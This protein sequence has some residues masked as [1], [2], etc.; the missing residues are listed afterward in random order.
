MR[1]T[2]RAD[3]IW[4]AQLHHH[5]RGRARRAGEI[6]SVG[7]AALRRSPFR[8]GE[9]I[10]QIA[11][12]EIRKLAWLSFRPKESQ[13]D[14]SF[15]FESDRDK[16]EVHAGGD[17]TY[18]LAFYENVQTEMAAR[19]IEMRV[20]VNHGLV[21]L[22]FAEA[23]YSRAATN[24]GGPDLCTVTRSFAGRC[25]VD[26]RSLEDLRMEVVRGAEA[27]VAAGVLSGTQHGNWSVR[28]PGTDRI[29]LTGSSLGGLKP[30]DL[31]VLNLDG[32]VIEGGLSASSAE[33]IRMHTAVY[34]ERPEVGSV[35]HTHSPYATAFAVANRPL[36]CF[37]E[38][39]AR[40]GCSDPV[41]VAAYGPRGSEQAVANILEA[42]RQAPSQSAVLLGNHGILAF[43]ANVGA[44]RQ[45]VFALEETAQLGVLAA[46][47]GTPQAIPTHMVVA[48][49]AR[50]VTSATA[51]ASE[52]SSRQ[53]I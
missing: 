32:E 12:E 33:I 4:E 24:P 29:L 49:Q 34:L 46:A 21:F 17:I 26:E 28:I 43:G 30:T 13:S 18:Q 39:L 7:G 2:Q 44:A 5:R 40:T 35:V 23:M 47:I 16:V 38:I 14:Q 3:S 50:R 19:Q 15:S 22:A 25:M 48:A 20:L 1:P 31:A 11:A 37:A 42:M 53:A 51:G 45:M 36:E 8:L 10:S 52:G 9:A 41:P 6:P 27:L